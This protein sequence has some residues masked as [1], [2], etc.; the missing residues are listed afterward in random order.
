M[1]KERPELTQSEIAREVGVSRVLVCKLLT[2]SKLVNNLK[3][4]R[5]I[6]I[7]FT[8]DPARVAVK[9][10][11]KMGEGYAIELRDSLETLLKSR[12]E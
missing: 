9:I 7:G 12:A 11:Q 5:P 10:F 8:S 6:M 2:N 3:A 1:L 4:P